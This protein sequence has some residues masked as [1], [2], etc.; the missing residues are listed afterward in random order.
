M[1]QTTTLPKPSFNKYWN[2]YS[3]FINGF[4]VERH[5]TDTGFYIHGNYTIDGLPRCIDTEADLLSFVNNPNNL[6]ALK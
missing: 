1:L 3:W 4:S 5:G 2:T 6:S